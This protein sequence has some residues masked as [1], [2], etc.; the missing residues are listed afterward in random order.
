MRAGV[1]LSASP[2]STSH[3]DRSLAA[4]VVAQGGT[5]LAGRVAAVLPGPA[6]LTIAGTVGG[7]ILWGAP[8]ELDQSPLHLLKSGSWGSLDPAM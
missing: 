8:G 7:K 5:A 1:P 3:R 4:A 6:G 2:R